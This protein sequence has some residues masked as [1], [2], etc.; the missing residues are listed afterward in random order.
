MAANI[1][2]GAVNENFTVAGNWSSGSVPTLSDGDVA[3][4]DATSPNCTIINN[5]VCNNVDFTNYTNTITINFGL[6]V[7]GDI[8]LGVNMIFGGGSSIIA[9]KTGTL[10]SNGKS[11]DVL[12]RFAGTNQTYTLADNWVMAGGIYFQGVTNTYINGGSI[13]IPF[14]NVTFT[15]NGYTVRGTSSLTL[16]GT[17]TW[18]HNSGSYM[19][20]D[21]TFNTTG[22]ITF[23]A[24]G[25][26]LINNTF[27]YTSGTLAGTMNLL[28]QGTMNVDSN[29]I[30]WTSLTVI[31][32]ATLNLLSDIRFSGLAQLG[33]TLT[34]NGSYTFYVG[35]E[36]RRTSN[37][38]MTFNSTVVMYGDSS[39]TDLYPTQSIFFTDLRI[40]CTTFTINNQV[41][42][43]GKLTYVSGVV[44][45]TNSTVTIAS[46]ST[47]DINSDTSSQSTICSTGIN[48]NNLN[49]TANVV[50]TI[51][52]DIRVCGQ[53]T[54]PGATFT[55]G[56]TIYVAGTYNVPSNTGTGT[57]TVLMDGSGNWQG[58]GGV[59]NSLTFNTLGTINITSDV[60]FSGGN[61][62][63]KYI[64][65]TVITTGSR[66]RTTLGGTI[67]IDTDGIVWNELESSTSGT[68]NFISTF[69]SN[70]ITL[71]N[72]LPILFTG[73]F[74]F[75]VGRFYVAASSKNINFMR[76]NIYL[77]KNDLTINSS[78]C[79]IFVSSFI[80]TAYLTLQHGATQNVSN[81]STN[82][83]NSLSGQTIWANG[84]TLTLTQNWGVGIKQDT[85]LQMF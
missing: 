23:G 48:L 1:F 30:I 29:P 74:G 67:N 20:L 61:G 4:F 69:K 10:T 45:A 66:L 79:Y 64:S 81:T 54:Q 60:N 34:V 71:T 72:T 7:N 16:T 9:N 36:I 84:G 56:R 21:T 78:N 40:D 22:T 55:N 80:G 25:F 52:S 65:G 27:V 32:T 17:H 50:I 24:N 26:R 53:L 18:T 31:N 28:L 42:L 43:R 58:T 15:P 63:L 12:F 44:D 35:G 38:I 59:R 46:T 76:D 14:G 82:R 41:A 11:F 73:N 68:F 6:T 47:L 13:I 51:P 8:T 85:M 3:T 37:L 2:T 57:Y 5:S 77:I 62:I 39:W 33:K 49:I 19:G 83:I 75:E 70:L